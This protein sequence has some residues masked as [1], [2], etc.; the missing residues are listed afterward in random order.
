MS[1]LRKQQVLAIF[2][3]VASSF[4]VAGYRVL[5]TNDGQIVDQ[6]TQKWLW[7]LRLVQSVEERTKLHSTFNQFSFCTGLSLLTINSCL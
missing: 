3:V 2:R 1:P 6:H 5:N 4:H 7:Q